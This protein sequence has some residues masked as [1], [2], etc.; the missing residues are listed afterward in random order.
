MK[1]GV[2]DSLMEFSPAYGV[3]ACAKTMHGVLE[4]IADTRPEVKNVVKV[5]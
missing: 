1:K 2:L 5:M 3:V 4:A